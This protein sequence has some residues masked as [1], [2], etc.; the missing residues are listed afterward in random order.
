MKRIIAC[1]AACAAVWTA[2][3]VAGE[4][5]P[6]KVV[7]AVRNQVMQW[8]TDR[9]IVEAVRAEN[10]KRKTLDQIKAADQKWIAT[11]G[12]TDEMRSLM[13]S[14]CGKRLKALQATRS[15]VVELFVM[16]NQGALVA[17]TNKTSDYW[18]G[19]EDKFVKSY[20]GG[21]GALHL[22]DVQFDDST[23]MYVVQASFPVKDGARVIGAVTVGIS[24]EQ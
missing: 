1:L 6:E 24:V 3:A 5:A 2:G 10:A 21:A 19:D 18:Q 20:N 14:A 22:S 8:G 13:E 16:D 15:D 12:V 17:M 4:K 11:P 23:Q 7:S 9:V